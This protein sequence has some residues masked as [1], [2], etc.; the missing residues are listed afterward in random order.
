MQT[1]A[2]FNNKGGVGKTTL[3]YHLGHMLARMDERVLMVDLDPQSN[4]TAMCLLEDDLEALWSEDSKAARTIADGFEPLRRGIGDIK[5]VRRIALNDT[6]AL[7]PGSLRL[8]LV[9]DLLA[10][11][12]PHAMDGQEAAFR[13]LSAFHRIIK[14]AARGFRATLVL[15]DVGP[16]LGAINRV[17]LL[18]ADHV[19]SPLAPDLF[20]IQGL[21]NLGPTLKRWREQWQKRLAQRPDDLDLPT[22]TMAPL[23]YFIMQAGMRLDRPTKAYHRWVKRIPTV[24]NN[25]M[26]PDV[27]LPDIEQV[28]RDDP[29]CLGVVRHYHS[30]MAFAHDARK[31]IFDLRAGDGA[32]GSHATLARRCGDEFR[33]FSAR[34]LE[35][36]PDSS[37]LQ[38]CVSAR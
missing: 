8:S 5:S 2:L 28:D 37:T 36:L 10:Q 4:L 18:S 33:G 23:G 31:P 20:S 27:A 26:Q 34:I 12:W 11:S 7:L 38:G 29:A 22:G 35:R 13:K 9:E 24:Y 30:L 19:I 32:L 3:V 16:N 17:A 1:L 6:L 15:I 14:E 25:Q 21:R